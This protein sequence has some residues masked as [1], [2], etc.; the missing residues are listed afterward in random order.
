MGCTSPKGLYAGMDLRGI[1]KLSDIT[2][3]LESLKASKK[4]R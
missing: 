2:S 4:C 1:H 3:A